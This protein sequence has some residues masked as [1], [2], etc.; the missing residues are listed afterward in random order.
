MTQKEQLIELLAD[1]EH[2]QWAHWTLY[3]LDNMTDE[4]IERWRKQINTPYSDLSETEKDSDREWARK[5][6]EVVEGRNVRDNA[7]T[8]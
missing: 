5:I 6:L 2:Q 7:G 1:L 8:E 4:N 3:M